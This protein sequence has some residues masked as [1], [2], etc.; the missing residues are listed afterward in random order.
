MA[1]I[2]EQ[3]NAIGRKALADLKQAGNL[4]ELEQFRIQYLSRKGEITSLLSKLG[5]LPDELRPQVGQLGGNI[6]AP[7][8]LRQGF[9]GEIAR[10]KRDHVQAAYCTHFRQ[11]SLGRSHD[12]D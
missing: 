8:G 9:A 11:R 6:F 2:L 10:E 5:E 7:V 3:F 1:D 4:E 12:C